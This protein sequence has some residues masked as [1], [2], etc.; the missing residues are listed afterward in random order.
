MQ[1][2][3]QFIVLILFLSAVGGCLYLTH[4]HKPNQKSSIE[5]ANE[6][7][8][9]D[10]YLRK[11]CAEIE[12]Y[13]TVTHNLRQYYSEVKEN[14]SLDGI[15]AFLSNDNKAIDSTQFLDDGRFSIDGNG[16]IANI[17]LKD[18]T[19]YKITVLKLGKCGDKPKLDSLKK[20]F[21]DEPQEPDPPEDN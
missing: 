18:G 10:N 12:Y 6:K 3:Y 4:T 8:K 1:N 5:I 13:D 2:R 17:T 20:Y 19:H 7:K 9:F 21:R 15:C 14:N 11:W 16:S